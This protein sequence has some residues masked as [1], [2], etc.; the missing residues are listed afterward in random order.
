MYRLRGLHLPYPRAEAALRGVK[1]SMQG[2]DHGCGIHCYFFD[3][4]SGVLSYGDA[5]CFYRCEINLIQTDPDA[6]KMPARFGQRINDLGRERC[7]YESH[8]IDAR[9]G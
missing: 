9:S 3:G 7:Q 6:L 5:S 8:S 1:L 2:Q 4:V